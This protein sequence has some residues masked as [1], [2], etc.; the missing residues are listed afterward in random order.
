[1]PMLAQRKAKYTSSPFTTLAL[2]GNGSRT[3]GFTPGE[4]WY[5][6]WGRLSM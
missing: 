3:G 6:L 1:M 4:D 5:H 2:E